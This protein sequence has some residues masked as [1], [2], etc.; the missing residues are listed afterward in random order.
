MKK[1]LTIVIF[2]VFAGCAKEHRGPVRHEE[3]KRHDTMVFQ[4][5]IHTL[6]WSIEKGDRLLTKVQTTAQTDHGR[7]HFVMEKQADLPKG[8]RIIH[9]LEV[10]R[11]KNDLFTR[12]DGSTFMHWSSF[13]NEDRALWNLAFGDLNLLLQV[14]EP[15]YFVVNNKAVTT[16]G[17]CKPDFRTS[18]LR[19]REL[20]KIWATDNPTFKITGKQGQ[21]GHW[22]NL[23]I[24]LD[25]G[26]TS[27]K[28]HLDSK[29]PAKIVINPPKKWVSDQRQSP[30]ASF[31]HIKRAIEST[32]K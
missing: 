5:A 16:R 3:I 9:R 2:W 13:V 24:D 17:L 15:C 11:T 19:A 29:T 8:I 27:L 32:G 7:F 18:D 30:W 1:V 31:Q 20:Q 4:K 22:A 14:F 26:E 6:N 25:I 28:M 10:I 21:N 23:D 12:V